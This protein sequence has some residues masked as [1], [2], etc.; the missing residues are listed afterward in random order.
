MPDPTPITTVNDGKT[1]IDKEHY[2][3]GELLDLKLA[4]GSTLVIDG[5]DITLKSLL[6]VGALSNTTIELIHGA[7]LTVDGSLLD[8]NALNGLTY[9]IGDQSLLHLKQSFLDVK[10]LNSETI[11]FADPEGTGTFHYTPGGVGLRLS[12]PMKI[13]NLHV[14]DKIQVDGATSAEVD[15]ERLLFHGKGGAII[16]SFKVEEGLELG[17]P[18]EDGSFT[19]EVPCFLEGT[20]ISTPRGEIRVE[21]LKKGDL[22]HTL[23]G[24]ARAVTWVGNRTIFPQTANPRECL[25]VHIRPGALA[26]NMPHRDLYLSPDHCLF[27]AGC[28]IPAKFLINGTTI[29]QDLRLEPFTYYHIELE[30]HAVL[31]ADG[32]YTES[33]LDLGN[34]AMFLEPGMFMFCKPVDLGTVVHCFPPVYA[35]PVL[36]AVRNVLEQRAAI[37]RDS[38]QTMTIPP[39]QSCP[40]S[41]INP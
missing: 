2:S 30:Q 31:V 14:G 39:V 1:I 20:L 40:A 36:D 11:D 16:A 3:S 27:L 5:V 25:P 29:T 10:L 4:G 22:V 18:N 35:G 19:I 23:N 24:E 41:C 9:K 17:Q 8:V 32:A 33:Y 15:G 12:G 34:R 6:G 28:L 21:Y 38:A 13:I 26:E 7:T 37:A